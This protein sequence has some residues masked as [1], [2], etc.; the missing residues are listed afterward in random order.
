MNKGKNLDAIIKHIEKSELWGR[1]NK[2]C[3]AM[4][5]KEKR[6]PSEEEYQALRNMLISKVMMEDPEVSEMMAKFTWEELQE[7]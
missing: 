3:M 7:V 1:L 4:Y 6:V 5:E 2:K